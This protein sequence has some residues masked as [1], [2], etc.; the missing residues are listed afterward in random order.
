MS[1][2]GRVWRPR[3][4]ETIATLGVIASLVF[5]GLEI[6]QN[7]AATEGATLQAMS[8][9]H[10]QILLE[11][12]WDEGFLNLFSQALFEGRT[13]FSREENLRLGRYYIAHLSHLENTYLQHQKGLVDETV[14]ES[15]GWPSRL[16]QTPHFRAMFGGLLRIGVNPEFADFFTLRTADLPVYAPDRPTNDP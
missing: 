11:S 10:T 14:F 13:D 4:G 15:Y 6:R 16:W 12:T 2:E 7:T 9:M 5:V 3:L 1:D 8:D